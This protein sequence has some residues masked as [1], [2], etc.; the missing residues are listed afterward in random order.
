MNRT[1]TAGWPGA[2]GGYKTA[3]VAAGRAKGTIKL[4]AFYLGHLAERHRRPWEVTTAQ[5]TEFVALERWRQPETRKSARSALCGFYRWGHG[6]GYVAHDASDLLPPVHVPIPEARPA[7]ELVV[8]QMV[9]GNKPE[10]IVFM[11]LLAAEL[12]MR[13]GEIAQV[14]ARDY[15]LHARI[16][17]VRGKGGKVRYLPVESQQLHE[18][19]AAVAGDWAFPNGRGS[20]LTPGHVSK[21]LSKALPFDFTG[22]QLRHRC[23]TVQHEGTGDLLAVSKFLGHSRTETTQRYIRFPQEGLRR[24]GRASVIA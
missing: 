10:R 20:H 7:P 24:A 21:L 11:S 15:D 9:R 23:A 19:M 1:S 4:H 3:Q 17:L 2:L 22:H 12:G 5:L 16:L 13:V 14:H 8:R 18:C 6:M